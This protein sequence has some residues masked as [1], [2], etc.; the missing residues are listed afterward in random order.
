MILV[1]LISYFHLMQLLILSQIPLFIDV[2]SSLSDLSFKLYVY[3]TLFHGL[4]ES[5]IPL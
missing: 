4:L 3:D 5:L 2:I 1:H